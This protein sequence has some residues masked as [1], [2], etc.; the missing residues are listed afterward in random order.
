MTEEAEES[1]TYTDDRKE[2]NLQQVIDEH[3]SDPTMPRY[4]VVLENHPGGK[5]ILPK[6]VRLYLRN[7]GRVILED[8][9]GDNAF[10]Y[11]DSEELIILKCKD[12]D[13]TVQKPA[14]ICDF[15]N[16]EN[17]RI[18][19]ID[20]KT[21]HTNCNASTVEA[22]KLSTGKSTQNDTHAKYYESNFE[23]LTTEGSNITMDEVSIMFDLIMKKNSEVNG[24]KVK[25]QKVDIE[26][27][28]ARFIDLMV[29]EK[30]KFNK[31]DLT[32]L[33]C[34]RGIQEMEVKESGYI[35]EEIKL[36]A[37]CKYEKSSGS[38]NKSIFLAK[39][40][41][42]EGQANLDSNEVKGDATFAKTNLIGNEDKFEASVAQSEAQSNVLNWTI[43]G[44]YSLRE[45][46]AIQREVNV[47]G[48]YSATGGSLDSK[49][50][51]VQGATTISQLVGR[52]SLKK[53]SFA[54]GLSVSGDDMAALEIVENNTQNLSVSGFSHV[55]ADRNTASNN[56]YSSVSRLDLSGASGPHSMSNVGSAKVEG[57]QGSLNFSSGTLHASNVSG[58]VNVTGTTFK[59]TDSSTI[60]AANSVGEAVN[61]AVGALTNST[62]TA[63]GSTP[64]GPLYYYDGVLSG[65]PTIKGMPLL[66]ITSDAAVLIE[67]PLVDINGI[68]KING[69]I[70]A[71]D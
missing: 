15:L 23:K 42:T 56:S 2:A 49:Q 59:I 38:L 36:L 71:D 69:I 14:K 32:L 31:C 61:T 26:E 17:C 39:L 50:L 16:M 10:S 54:G 12:V 18:K 60:M 21:K 66:K 35:C 24:N 33:N 13:L 19:L 34:M 43:Q 3:I 27:S 52:N 65:I 70:Q 1:V 46:T 28:R 9:E 55:R 51:T 29:T 11:V 58:P 57:L 30:A 37:D 6:H 22:I 67:A 41:M 53:N 48:S 7:C 62:L 64:V 68:V 47:Q 25:A 5:I 44:S 45:L 4:T 40:D 8:S 20:V 63:V